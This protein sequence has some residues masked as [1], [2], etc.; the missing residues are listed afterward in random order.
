MYNHSKV[1]NNL[2]YFKMVKDQME[3]HS[4]RTQSIHFRH[5]LLERQKVAN[6][7]NELDRV[8]GELSRTVLNDTTKMSLLAREKQLKALA[9]ESLSSLK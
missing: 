1:K 3:K 5:N 4:L 7:H 2:N 9:A 8:R 6:Y